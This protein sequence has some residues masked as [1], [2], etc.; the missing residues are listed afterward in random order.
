ML[1]VF[2]NQNQLVNSKSTSRA[3]RLRDVDKKLM[4]HSAYSITLKDKASPNLELHVYTP[5]GNLY[6]TGAHK[7]PYTVESNDNSVNQVSQFLSVDANNVLQSLGITQ[8]AYKVVYNIFDNVLGDFTNKLWIESISPSRK[9][10]RAYF[11]DDLSNTLRAQSVKLYDRINDNT[12]NLFNSY[13]LNLGNNNTLQI[14]NI[15]LFSTDIVSRPRFGNKLLAQYRTEVLIKLYDPLPDT[16]NEKDTFWISE[17]LGQSILKNVII[18][19]RPADAVKSNLAGPNFDIDVLD[20]ESIATNYKNWNDLL[21]SNLPTSQKLIDTYISSSNAGIQLNIN[22]RDFNNFVHFSS[23]EERVKNFKYKLELIESYTDRINLLRPFSGS[24]GVSTNLTDLYNKRNQIVSNFDGF[25]KYLFFETDDTKIYTNYDATGSID[26]WP[27]QTTSSLDPYTYFNNLYPSDSAT[28][29]TYYVD[30]LQTAQ[31]Y[32]RYNVHKLTSAI[33]DQIY[34]SEYNEEFVL[35]INMLG[36]HYDV[37]W[38]YINGI[39]DSLTREEHPKD[40]MPNELLYDVAK[41]MGFKLLNHKSS[42][43]LWRYALGTDASGSAYQTSGSNADVSSISEQSYTYEVWR[44]IVNNLPYI[45]KSKGTSRSVKALLS[46]FGIPSTILSIKEYGGPSSFTTEA[47]FY[48]EYVHDTFKYAWES[49]TA[50]GSIYTTISRYNNGNSLVLPNTLEFQFKT[51]SNYL[52]SLNSYYSIAS[53]SSGSS[54]PDT[55]HILLRKDSDT[56][57]KGTIILLNKNTGVAVSA[58]NLEIFDQSWH[59]IAYNS[60]NNTGSFKIVRS[61]YGKQ[62]Y[63]YSASYAGDLNLFSTT[64]RN[65]YFAS[66]SRTILSGGSTL[67]NGSTTMSLSKFN[68]HFREIRLWSGSLNDASLLEHSNS[69]NT[70]TYNSDRTNLTSGEQGELPY[71]NLLQR[72]SLSTNQIVDNSN[73]YTQPSIHPDQNKNIGNGLT[74]TGSIYF[75]GY[76]TTGSI[77]FLGFEETYYTPSPSLGGNS[78]YTNKIRIESSSIDG[79][80]NIQTRVEKSS[81]DKYSLDSNRLGIYF[82]PQNGINEDIFNQLGYFEIDDYIGNPGDVYNSTYTDL[83]NFS[84]RYWKKYSSKNSFETYFKSLQIYDFTLF[85]YLKQILPLRANL[86]LGLV[87]EP[88]VLERSKVAVLK[89]PT[90]DNSLTHNAIY[91]IADSA[92][93]SGVYSNN[94]GL[95]TYNVDIDKL[96]TQWFEKRYITNHITY[97]FTG[98]YTPIQLYIDNSITSNYLKTIKDRFYLTAASASVNNYYSSSLAFAQIN[99]IQDL[100]YVNA[101]Y[102]GSKLNGLGININ[103]TETVD[104][105]PVVKVTKVNPNQLVFANNQLT[106]I[107]QATTGTKSKPIDSS[108]IP[109]QI[110][111]S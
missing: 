26:P 40:G 91:N 104:G 96:G 37:V 101:T 46:C 78:L 59:T 69:P 62:T 50:T 108:T 20:G 75:I 71:N 10:I 51:D 55:Y 25:E 111:F 93:L 6:L 5:D 77:K 94:E 22:Y 19:P 32:D 86:I 58:S 72:Y 52:Y 57:N 66:G 82:S 9:E 16:F 68:G 84:N 3:Y 11:V 30:L 107:N 7:V 17:E 110:K 36:Q 98:S 90:V 38:T 13:V 81:F 89:K 73:V 88:N 102:N 100:G 29:L 48:P 53:I 61:L 15:S 54:S 18:I 41:S 49:N 4:E 56:T 97:T 74:D 27:K 1:S 45:L 67:P 85:R 87:I 80:L 28:G 44:R 70:Y 35:F 2:A 12:L 109:T 21:S 42:S 39:T 99:P 92:V 105:G 43:E 31:D 8:G 14:V 103:S 76:S 106:T 34:G 64:S 83:I 65:L 79:R 63:N 95:I 23:A 47:S 24:I 60:T 33:P